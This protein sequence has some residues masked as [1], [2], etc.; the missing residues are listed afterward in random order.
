MLLV[1]GARLILEEPHDGSYREL[2]L[3]DNEKTSCRHQ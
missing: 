2:G 1:Q 3:V